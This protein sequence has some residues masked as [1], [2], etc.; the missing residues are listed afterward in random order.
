LCAGVALESIAL[1]A[2]SSAPS[3]LA[4]LASRREHSPGS[5]RRPRMS[6]EPTSLADSLQDARLVDEL[7]AF[8]WIDPLV[9]QGESDFGW[10]CRDHALVI[11][12]FLA[13][14]GA[15]V[16][17]RHGKCMFVLGPSS[18]GAPPMGMGQ[19]VDARVGHTW[20]WVAGLGDVDLSPK[21]NI[22]QP[23]WPPI[24]SSGI[25][26]SSWVAP[27]TTQFIVTGSPR[28]YDRE[29]A[30][31]THEPDEWWA[32]YFNERAEPFGDQIARTGLSWAYSPL[33]L[34]LLRRGLP[35]DL[36][37]RFAAHLRGVLSGD[38]RS[39]RQLSR[40]KAWAILAQDPD[41]TR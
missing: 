7:H 36:Y 34:R 16:T 29:I 33:S 25:V 23:G 39:L 38:R 14:A 37:L 22:S 2:V 9:N 31:A 27:R 6:S 11:G 32:I 8:M 3:W 24:E 40:N 28:E 26:G 20:L 30:R 12:Q 13:D 21:L 15:S 41:L 5:F 19:G 17:V 1:A 10:S 35:D 4:V 18:D